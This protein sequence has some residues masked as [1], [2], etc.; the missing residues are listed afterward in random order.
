[1][2]SYVDNV[3]NYE[4]NKLCYLVKSRF[5]EHLSS[6]REIDDD[7]LHWKFMHHN[8]DRTCVI[9]KILKTCAS[10]D[11]LRTVECHD[12]LFSLDFHRNHCVSKTYNS[13]DCRC[14]LVFDRVRGKF[15]RAR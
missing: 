6:F 11:L 7:D 1:M 3:K 8:V 15:V 12:I 4:C 5:I 2:N 9:M 13:I 14:Y 10:D